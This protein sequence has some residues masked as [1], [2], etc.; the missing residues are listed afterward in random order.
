[1]NIRKCGK[2][3]I[4]SAGAFYDR[5][6]F[7]LNERI[8]YPKWVYGVYPSEGSVRE[9]TNAGSQYICEEDGRIIGAFVLNTDPQGNYGRGNWKEN[10]HEGS[11]MVLHALAIDPEL[12][13]MGLA[14]EVI[15]FCAQKAGSEGYKA[16]RV[17]VVPDNYPAKKLF[18]ANGFIYAG[19]AD[20]ERGLEDIPVFSLFEL[21]F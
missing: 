9:M 21:N 19:D 16:L 15:R 4:A 12:Y 8:N 18:E 20:L 1:M 5:I 14:S 7:W 17:D 10:L 13:G 2:E 11:Y 3:D 6:V